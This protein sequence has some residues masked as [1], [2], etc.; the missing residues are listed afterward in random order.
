MA[1][2][3]G[4]L[5]GADTVLSGTLSQVSSSIYA[6]DLSTSTLAVLAPMTLEF[7]NLTTTAIGVLQSGAITA[8]FNSSGVVQSVSANTARVGALA[9]TYGGMADTIAIQNVS[10]NAGMINGS[11]TLLFHFW[12][13]NPE[14]GNYH[15]TISS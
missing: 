5:S 10:A 15:H 11:A 1:S 7:G 14:M 13:K 2:I 9:E 12:S 3:I 8:T 6:Q 4:D